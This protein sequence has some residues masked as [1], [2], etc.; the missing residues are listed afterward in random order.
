[1]S[2]IRLPSPLLRKISIRIFPTPMN[3][4]LNSKLNFRFKEDPTTDTFPL[5]RRLGKYHELT[6]TFEISTFG[7]TGRLIHSNVLRSRR[8]PDEPVYGG[9]TMVPWETPAK[10]PVSI[11]ID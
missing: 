11:E 4:S 9:E 10:I 7:T 2:A 5:C 8:K 3:P 1:M 6:S